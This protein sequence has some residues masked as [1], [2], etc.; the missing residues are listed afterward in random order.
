MDMT[1]A[2]TADSGQLAAPR[3][4]PEASPRAGDDDLSSAY[5]R[6]LSGDTIN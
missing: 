4:S 5:V 6:A 3:D 1:D 2:L